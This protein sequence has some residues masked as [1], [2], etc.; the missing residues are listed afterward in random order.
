MNHVSGETPRKKYILNSS[1]KKKKKERKQFEN[2][3]LPNPR[4]G[5]HPSVVAYLWFNH[6][7][8]GIYVSLQTPIE[9]TQK[10]GKFA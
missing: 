4:A 3:V 7:T 5:Y 10:N 2:K 1:Q 9:K 8:N 6:Y